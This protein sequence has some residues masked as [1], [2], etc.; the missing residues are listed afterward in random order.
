MRNLFSW[1]W[2]F[3]K[4]HLFTYVNWNRFIQTTKILLILSIV[5][6]PSVS[7]K[8]WIATIWIF[9]PKSSARLV[10]PALNQNQ[11]SKQKSRFK[12]HR[13][14]QFVTSL[15]SSWLR[16][17]RQLWVWISKKIKIYKIGRLRVSN[18]TFWVLYL[19]RN[20]QVNIVCHINIENAVLWI[21]PVLSR[22][23]KGYCCS[24][25]CLCGVSV[26][27][28]YLCLFSPLF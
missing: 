19:S 17:R 20:F 3:Y 1:R 24:L 21:F 12:K 13:V 14:S 6:Q 16:F 10:A 26:L 25:V 9:A 23:E 8:I 27:T 22:T 11:M 18:S 4:P 7:R 15:D 28:I 2:A 5:Q